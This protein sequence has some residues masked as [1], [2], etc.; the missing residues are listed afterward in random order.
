MV[1]DYIST[2]FLNGRPVP[3]VILAGA[4]RGTRLDEAVFA[5]RP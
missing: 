3:I 5:A 1:G 4:P 2:S